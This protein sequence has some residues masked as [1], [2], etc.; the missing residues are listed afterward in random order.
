[1]MAASSTLQQLYRP[2]YLL[3]LPFQLQVRI[4]L[5]AAVHLHGMGMEPQVWVEDAEAVDPSGRPDT[6]MTAFVSPGAGWYTLKSILGALDCTCSEQSCGIDSSREVTSLDLSSR[7]CSGHIPAE[8]CKLE[9]LRNLTLDNNRLQGELP[10]CM[11]QLQRLELLHLS[12]KQLTGRLPACVG[13]MHQ[14]RQLNL[15]FHRFV[16]DIPTEVCG[17]QNL[18][19]LDP[20]RNQWLVGGLP[21][22]L[23]GS[24]SLRHLRLAE[25]RLAG[26]PL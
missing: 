12:H 11:C 8:L 16:G 13:Q 9:H 1:M 23:G 7:R 3:A 21:G 5:S 6:V 25:N 2:Y 10:W 15:K 22:C 17:L 26:V 18:E 24:T 20:S 14:L 4:E 19:G